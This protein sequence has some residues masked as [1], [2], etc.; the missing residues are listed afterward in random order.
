MIILVKIN[1]SYDNNNIIIIIPA[2]PP[3]VRLHHLIS[4]VGNSTVYEKAIILIHPALEFNGVG[5]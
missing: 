4:L 2:K 5:N 3:Q 1:C